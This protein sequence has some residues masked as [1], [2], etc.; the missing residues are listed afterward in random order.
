MTTTDMAPE[1]DLDR[2]AT[3]AHDLSE[4]LRTGDLNE[5]RA[6]LVDLCA[7]HPVKAAQLLMVLAA[8]VDPVEPVGLRFARVE[9]ITRDRVE[10]R[11]SA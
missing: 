9:Y 8:W 7:G 6:A 2:L 11:L 10:L 1:T 3:I 4:R 5:M